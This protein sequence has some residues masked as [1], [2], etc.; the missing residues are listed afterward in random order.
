MTFEKKILLEKPEEQERSSVSIM[1]RKVF[2]AIKL[3]YK[4]QFTLIMG[5]VVLVIILE[6]LTKI[7]RLSDPFYSY[8]IGA[9]YASNL[10][11]SWDFWLG[12]DTGSHDIFVM[13]LH[14]TRNSIYF[15]IGC[16]LLSTT[17]AILLGVFGPFVGGKADTL[18][19]FITNIFMVFPQLPFIFFIASL[20]KTRS[21]VTVMIIIGSF[22]WPWAARSI[23]SQVLTL[24]ERNFIKVSKM[25]ALGNMRIAFSEVVP[26]VLTYILLVFCISFGIGIITEAGISMLGLGDQGQ[27]FITLG[28]VMWYHEPYNM[29]PHYYNIWISPG[30]VL[31]LIYLVFFVIQSSFINTFNPRTRENK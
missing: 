16:A 17:L 3:R 1:L 29:S 7:P 10:P 24:R 9:S 11:P 21:W 13:I 31:V 28:F 20:M 12:T 18:S 19:S 25:S 5:L 6:I 22:S 8:K 27:N 26:N 4:T 30:I 23:R 15:G 14:G 2:Q